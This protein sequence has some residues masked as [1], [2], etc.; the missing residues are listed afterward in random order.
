VPSLQDVQL[1]AVPSWPDTYFA[2]GTPAANT[3]I[4]QADELAPALA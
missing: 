1:G 2:A 3:E 4:L